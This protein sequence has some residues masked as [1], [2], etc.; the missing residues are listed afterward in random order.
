M[1]TIK[2]AIAILILKRV[3]IFSRFFKQTS[4]LCSLTKNQKYYSFVKMLS[5]S[6]D[7]RD[8]HF[9]KNYDLR[10]QAKLKP[11]P[12]KFLHRCW[13]KWLQ[14][15]RAYGSLWKPTVLRKPRISKETFGLC[16]N[17]QS[18]RKL[19]AFMTVHGFSENPRSSYK[20]VVSV[21]AHGPSKSPWSF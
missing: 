4:A 1:S 7:T 9:H 13:H 17:L 8:I 15:S 11:K 18:L 10:S 19:T 2:R 21:K 12:N 6:T 5:S 16:E 14:V 3:V 20:A